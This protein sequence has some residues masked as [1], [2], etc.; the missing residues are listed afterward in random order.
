VTYSWPDYEVTLSQTDRYDFADVISSLPEVNSFTVSGRTMAV[1]LFGNEEQIIIAQDSGDIISSVNENIELEGRL[2]FVTQRVSFNSDG[3]FS[4]GDSVEGIWSESDD[5]VVLRYDNYETHLILLTDDNNG[6]I[7]LIKHY[8]DKD[9][10][11]H[12]THFVMDYQEIDFTQLKLFSNI[13]SDT[14][15]WVKDGVYS[16]EQTS[17]YDL[18]E[19]FGFLFINDEAVFQVSTQIDIDN[20]AWDM[21]VNDTWHY[22]YEQRTDGLTI[23]GILNYERQYG[24]EGLP[25]YYRSRNWEIVSFDDEKNTLYVLERQFFC[26][27]VCC[28]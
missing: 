21:Y 22:E 26:Y 7:G 16:F 25:K 17:L 4:V 9:L 14:L 24:N 1:P 18:E 23:S 20:S 6:F 3:S 12:G 28:V 15:V 13:L 27:G 11:S 19:K 2:R 8:E 5:A 10:I